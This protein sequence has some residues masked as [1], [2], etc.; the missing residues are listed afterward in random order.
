VPSDEQRQRIASFA[1][2]IAEHAIELLPGVAETLSA[3]AQ[4]HRLILVT[5]GNAQ[6]QQKKLDR[7]GIHMHFAAVEIPPEKHSGAYREIV[8]RQLRQKSA[9]NSLD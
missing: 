2:S 4:R 1:Q 9:D 6:E 7:S 3:L 8:S 5:K